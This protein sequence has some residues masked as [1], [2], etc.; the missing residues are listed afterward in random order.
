MNRS[1]GFTLIE[2]LVVVA[3]IALLVAILVPAVQRAREQANRTVCGTRLKGIDTA[4]Y[5]YADIFDNEYPVG[6]D[7]EQ[8]ATEPGDWTDYEPLNNDLTPQDS[9]ALMV[10]EADLTPSMFICPTVGGNE[11]ADQY[12]LIGQGGLYDGSPDEAVENFIHYVYQDIDSARHED[13]IQDRG[14]YL[15]GKGPS[16]APIFAD[17][18]DSDNEDVDGAGSGNHDTKPGMQNVIGGAHG[19]TQARTETFDDLD[20]PESPPFIPYNE[21]DR[22]M[23]GYFNGVEYDNI[24]ADDDQDPGDDTYLINYEEPGG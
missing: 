3:I 13:L 15:A 11:A 10:H 16:N 20:R 24:Y 5:V 12:E 9:F 2:L 18:P 1:K 17:R 23:I 14:N 6:Y 7:H 4:C 22:C 21:T 19:G 8:H